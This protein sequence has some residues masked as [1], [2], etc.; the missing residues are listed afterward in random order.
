VLVDL[1]P[2]AFLPTTFLAFDGGGGATSAL[3]MRLLTRI[4]VEPAL[5]PPDEA[6]N[7]SALRARAKTGIVG[8]VTHSQSPGC[9]M[10]N[11]PRH[12]MKYAVY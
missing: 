10:R 5:G 1:V 11:Y 9:G 8:Y 3:V 4:L 7:E 12:A 6:L 2:Y